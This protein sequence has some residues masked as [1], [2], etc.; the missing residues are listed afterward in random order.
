MVRKPSAVPIV[1]RL[2][3]VHVAQMKLEQQRRDYNRVRIYYA[4]A[5]RAAARPFAVT[6]MRVPSGQAARS[7]ASHWWA[8]SCAPRTVSIWACLPTKRK[9]L[10]GQRQ[11]AP[12]L[13]AQT[14]IFRNGNAGCQITFRYGFCGTNAKAGN[15]TLLF[16]WTGSLCVRRNL[17][18]HPTLE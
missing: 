15:V 12:E 11:R 3:E 18:L 14:C 16:S 2:S 7:L 13:C 10:D 17:L 9:I 5:T 8:T 1:Q 6:R 4:H